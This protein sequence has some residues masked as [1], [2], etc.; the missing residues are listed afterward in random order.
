MVAEGERRS[1][2]FRA[3][4]A[5]IQ[6]TDGIVYVV[7]GECGR[8]VRACLVMAIARPGPYRLLQVRL[9]ARQRNDE[10]IAKLGHELRHAIEILQ[11]PAI[12]SGSEMYLF[13]KRFGTWVG[14]ATFETPAAVAAGDAIRR[15]LSRTSGGARAR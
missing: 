2:S 6:G 3:L 13:Y 15:E 9:D 10:T 1:R 14:D 5:A 8:G 7:E 11:E 12:A 4:L